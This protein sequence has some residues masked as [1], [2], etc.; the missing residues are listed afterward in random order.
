M[1]PSGGRDPVAIPQINL[2]IFGYG[3]NSLR[4][5]HV[6]TSAMGAQEISILPH[7]HGPISVLAGDP[8]R[9]RLSDNTWFAEW[10]YSQ[11]GTYIQWASI[12]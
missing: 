5:S 4:N 11:G 12:T 2:S 6:G 3:P 9:G 1:I 10:E 8:S 7:V